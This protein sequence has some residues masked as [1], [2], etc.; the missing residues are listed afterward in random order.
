M[1]SDLQPQGRVSHR[2]LH[3]ARYAGAGRLAGAQGTLGKPRAPACSQRPPLSLKPSRW[4]QGRTAEFPV[5]GTVRC[6]FTLGAEGLPTGCRPSL[7][8]HPWSCATPASTPRSRCVPQRRG[9]ASPRS[10]RLSYDNA[11]RLWAVGSVYLLSLH[12]CPTLP[13]PGHAP[14]P[15]GAHRRAWFSPSSRSHGCPRPEQ[16]LG[17]PTTPGPSPT[18]VQEEP[19]PGGHSAVPGPPSV[20]TVIPGTPENGARRLFH[21]RYLPPLVHVSEWVLNIS[22]PPNLSFYIN[23]CFILEPLSHFAVSLS[24]SV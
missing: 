22:A 14:A 13:R 7:P 20:T 2:P 4:R 17:P 1:L 10:G 24:T 16:P 11:A 5:A 3:T 12:L 19:S 8:P 15:P 6:C 23:L 21:Q 9:S 18:F